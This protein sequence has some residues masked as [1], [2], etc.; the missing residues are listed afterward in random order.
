MTVYELVTGGPELISKVF[1]SLRKMQPEREFKFPYRIADRK[2]ELIEII[3]QEY[4]IIEED[5]KIKIVSDCFDNGDIVFTYALEVLVAP[6]LVHHVTWA[7]VGTYTFVGAVNEAVQLDGGLKL[8]SG[9][10]YSWIEKSK[11][12][13][14][15]YGGENRQMTA[16]SL[17]GV[18]RNCGFTGTS[19]YHVSKIRVP[20]VVYLNLL[21]HVTDWMGGAGKTHIN[22]TPFANLIAQTVSEL[23]HKMPSAH[24]KGLSITGGSAS[25]PD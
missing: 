12:N 18:L 25:E 6:K 1:Y 19:D 11:V 9:G 10:N 3:N 14:C 21:T 17:E 8:F 16:D 7:N 5:A 22:L 4:G 24:G 2:Q 13:S 23:V 20:C 15:G